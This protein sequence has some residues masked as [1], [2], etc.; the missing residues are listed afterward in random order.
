MTDIE[1]GRM[2]STMEPNMTTDP[3]A[4]IDL[5]RPQPGVP[6]L[7]PAEVA[8]LEH[9]IR[10]YGVTCAYSCSLIRRLLDAAKAQE[11]VS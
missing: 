6:I 3:H 8:Q 10:A 5:I 2:V 7:T 11:A 1:T 9:H 4:R